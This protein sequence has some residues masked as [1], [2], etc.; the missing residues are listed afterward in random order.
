MDLILCS[1]QDPNQGIAAQQALLSALQH[2]KLG[3]TA[4]TAATNRVLALR[5][6][7]R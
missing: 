1:A 6:A 4:F 2:K 5:Q 3:R 7:L